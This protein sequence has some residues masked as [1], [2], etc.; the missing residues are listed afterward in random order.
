[1]TTG[2][3]GGRATPPFALGGGD[4][5]PVPAD[6]PAALAIAPVQ[7][8]RASLWDRHADALTTTAPAGREIVDLVGELL[9]A[10]RLP[11]LAR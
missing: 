4:R 2:I 8:R 1:M 7:Q 6:D 10:A 11:G 9:P 5:V 3:L